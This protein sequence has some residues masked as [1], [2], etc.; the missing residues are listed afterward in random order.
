MGVRTGISIGQQLKQKQEQKLSPQVIQYIKLLSKTTLELEQRIKEEIQDNPVLE[1]EENAESE[2]FESPM[3]PDEIDKA[4]DDIDINDMWD[5]YHN[6]PDDLYGHKAR[7]DRSD[8][9]RPDMPAE[10]RESLID[11]LREQI[12]LSDLEGYEIAIA[13]QIVG[14]VED[15]GRLRRSLQ[16]IADDIAFSTGDMVTETDVERVLAVVQ[17]FDPVGIAARSLQECLLVQAETLLDDLPGQELAVEILEKNYRAFTMKH[18]AELMTR[19]EASVEELSEALEL[20]KKLDP[21]PGYGYAEAGAATVIPDFEIKREGDE[22]EI[23]L[24]RRNA[25][26]LRLSRHYVRLM[27]QMA[28]ERGSGNNGKAEARKFLKQK[29]ESASWFIQSIQQRQETMTRVMYAIAEYQKDFILEGPGNLKPMVLKNIA[30]RIRMDVSTVSRVVNG[31]YVQTEFG[32]FELK[33]FF[34]EGVETDSGEMVSN[35]EVKALIERII[36]AED[37]LKP[38]SDQRVT[39]LLKEQGFIIARRTVTKY[40]EAVGQPVARLR[41]EVRLSGETA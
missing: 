20:I 1:Q 39:E 6:N 17:R 16:S 25:P 27:D 33:Y 28:A 5:V 7:V 22:I 36:Q 29:M 2:E 26:Q 4:E 23:I 21:R 24:N 14:S 32:V 30:E 3:D 10:Y 37:K 34:S 13:E 38:L 12:G 41:K 18:H 9:D 8:E 15:D 19:T 40:R 11:Q 31:K 35:R